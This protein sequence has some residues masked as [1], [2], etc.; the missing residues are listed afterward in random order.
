MINYYRIKFTEIYTQFFFKE[1]TKIL[2]FKQVI[3]T[4]NLDSFIKLNL[5]F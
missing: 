5:S 1:I 4:S 2:Q 3:F